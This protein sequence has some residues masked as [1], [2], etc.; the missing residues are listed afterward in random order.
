MEYIRERKKEGKIRH[1][2]F[3]CH[4]DIPVLKRFLEAYG[5]E[6][7]FCQLQLNYLDWEFQRGRQKVEILK[8]YDIPVWVMEPVRGGKLAKLSEEREAALKALRPDE[9]VVAWAFRFLESQPEIKMILSGMSNEEQLIEN[10]RTF[11]ES[12]PLNDEEM[13]AILKIADDMAAEK[14]VPCTACHYCVDHCPQGLDI[15]RLIE[16]YNEHIITKQAGLLAFIAPMVMGSLPEDKRPAACLHCRS[17]EDVCPQ[18]IK[19]SEV[20]EDFVKQL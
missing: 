12:R 17:C 9:G 6:M 3:S 10:V 14:Q 7:E 20:M 16:L 4:G 13:K 5:D 8:E 18:Q 2:G 19:I 1:L 15:P 11:E